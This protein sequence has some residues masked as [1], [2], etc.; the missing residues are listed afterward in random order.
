MTVSSPPPATTR[1]GTRGHLRKTR[2]SALC[3]VK[4]GSQKINYLRDL[5]N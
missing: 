1:A 5:K 3:R 4:N 2:K